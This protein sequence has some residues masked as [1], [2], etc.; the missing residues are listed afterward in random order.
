MERVGARGIGEKE[1]L[2]GT[3]RP[4]PW[5]EPAVQQGSSGCSLP[6]RRASGAE[7]GWEGGAVRWWRVALGGPSP[8]PDPP[9]R[10]LSEVGEPS[11][12][13]RAQV[14]RAWAAQWP[15]HP[16]RAAQLCKR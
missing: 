4:W 2:P 16:V 6:R 5:G 14:N 9:C 10:G 15:G 7:T 1:S 11:Q 8:P 3:G 12:V 13:H